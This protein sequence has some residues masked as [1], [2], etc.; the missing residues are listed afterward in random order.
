MRLTIGAVSMLAAEGKNN[1][2]RGAVFG[3]L[4]ILLDQPHTADVR[5]LQASEFYVGHRVTSCTRPARVHLHRYG[6]GQSRQQ[7]QSRSHRAEAAASCRRT[8]ERDRGNHCRDR[9]QPCLRRLSIQSVIATLNASPRRLPPQD[10]AS[11]DS[12]FQ[13]PHTR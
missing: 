1:K 6:P 13:S 7:C 3:E 11:S 2:D 8:A 9:L 12:F 5:T 10:A 4:S